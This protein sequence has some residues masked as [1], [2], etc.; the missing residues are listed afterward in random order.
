MSLR[1]CLLLAPLSLIG[2]A[3]AAPSSRLLDE[4]SDPSIQTCYEGEPT[5]LFCYNPPNGTPQDVEVDDVA[6][7]A[8]YL[9]AYG[10]ETRLGRL[11]SM[12]AADAPDCGEWSLY[13]RGTAMAVAKHVDNTVNTSVLFADIARTIDGGA[14]AT[15][16]QKAGAIIGCLTSGGSLG[17]QVNTS[18]PAYTASSYP[19]GYVTSGIV[20]KIVW[21][22]A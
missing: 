11:F 22:G 16:E 6:F 14:N 21:S 19:A 7:V 8:A 1:L 18:A 5:S 3:L 15:P 4:R 10:A 13:S 12:A 20:V 17:V 9:R 2:T